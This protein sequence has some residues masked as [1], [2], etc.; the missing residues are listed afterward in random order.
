MPVQM[1][2]KRVGV[3]QLKKASN[4]TSLLA[5][6]E[7]ASAVGIIQFRGSDTANDLQVG[8]KVY[9]GKNYHQLRMNGMNILVMDE[10]NV[11][12]VVAEESGAEDKKVST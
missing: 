2:G 10:D 4:N 9:Y 7:D 1:R 8:T 11:Y 3:E 6:P 12:A 5:M